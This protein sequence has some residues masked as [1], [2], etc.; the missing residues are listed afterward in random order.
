VNG[1][2]CADLLLILI[3]TIGETYAEHVTFSDSNAPCGGPTVL[4]IKTDI[5]VNS[6]DIASLGYGVIDAVRHQLLLA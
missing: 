6:A 4:D 2:F 3:F 1:R 5:S